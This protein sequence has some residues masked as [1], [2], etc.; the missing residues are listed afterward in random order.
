MVVAR[1]VDQIA[2]AGGQQVAEQAGQ[3]VAQ[4]LPEV[5]LRAVRRALLGWLTAYAQVGFARSPVTGLFFLAS[6]LV[7]PQHGLLGVVG[8]LTTNGWARL[9]GRPRAHI[10]EGYY[11]FNGLLLGLALGLFYRLTPNLLL[12]LALVSLLVVV[13]AAAARNLAERY[14][15]VPVLGLPFMVVTWVALLA[16][17]RFGQIE[18]T[19]APVFASALGA[20]VLPP[21]LELFLKS[22]GAVFF[23]LNVVSGALV[24]VGL[25]W[26]SRWSAL[27][28]A[29]GFAAGWWV[30]AALGGATTDLARH[31]IGL[32]FLLTSVAVGGV[33]VVLS[34][35]SIALSAAAGAMTAVTGAAL[36]SLLGVVGLPALA[37]PFILTTQLLLFALMIRAG[38]GGPRLVTGQPGTPEE[39]L[40]R[41]VHRARRYPDPATPLVHLPVLGRWTITQ[42]PD[43]QHTHQGLWSHAWDFE[44]SDEEGS[45]HK[46]SGAQVEDWYA[47]Q[48]PVVAAADGKVMRVINHIEDNP[49]GEVDTT[50]NWGNL[51]I[52][53]H[54]GDVFSLC[55]HLARGSVTVSEGQTV[56]RGQV[57][58]RVGNSG[59]SPVP[60][61]HFQL[62]HSAEIGA[63]TRYGE[64]L[65]Y[66]RVAPTTDRA[67]G[68]PARSYVTHG[69]PATG[70]T[71][72]ALA[73]DDHVRRAL[74]LP[75]GLQ[76]RWRV[77]RDVAPARPQEETWTSEINALGERALATDEGS[78]TFYSDAHYCTVLDYEGGAGTLLSLYAIAAARVPFVDQ[79]RAHWEDTPAST[80][81]LSTMARLAVELLLPFREAGVV[82]TRSQLRREGDRVVL[83][84][85]VSASGVLSA[86]PNLPDRFEVVWLEHAGPVSVTAWKGPRRTLHGEVIS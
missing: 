39:N 20:G 79:P 57:I 66:L 10:D 16:T 63:P 30:Y 43:G 64:L 48:A 51:V 21:A 23:Q 75:P 68:T 49:V 15:G 81:S 77:E 26:A 78:A 72:E 38:A 41:V 65:H 27:L 33:F 42:G 83:S 45:R 8:L 28:A 47:W 67:P 80:A 46:D 29:V 2:G 32:N 25:V 18:M 55:C 50:H 37:M 74:A 76:L 52:L 36:L 31:F 9:L 13:F 59:R 22:L 44:V 84:C 6:T 86:G 58:G 40:R 85:S 14:L 82:R 53:W 56:V 61:L 34:P 69:A 24:L 1:A 12:L 5:T 11:G 17:G 71:I 73:V 54:H 60:H 4:S 3:K 7:V 62:Q 19:V 35:G 70:D